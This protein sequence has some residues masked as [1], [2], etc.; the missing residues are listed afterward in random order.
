MKQ[1]DQTGTIFDTPGQN[2]AEMTVQLQDAAR[3]I[4]E[5]RENQ[6]A[7]DVLLR[8]LDPPRNEAEAWI[9]AQCAEALGISQVGIYE[10]LFW[11]GG[12]S[13]LAARVLAAVGE[14]FGIEIPLTAFLNADL[15]VAG[16]AAAVEESLAGEA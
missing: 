4:Q 2:A 14:H 5:M 3:I 11:L 15:T 13:L 16:I 7:A 10:D 8:N 9:A 12:H 1:Q 6:D